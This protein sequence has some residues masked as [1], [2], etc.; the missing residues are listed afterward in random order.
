MEKK[1][2]AVA[3]A[4]MTMF[5]MDHDSEDTNDKSKAT[6]DLRNVYKDIAE[7]FPSIVPSALNDHENSSE[8]VQKKITLTE[9]CIQ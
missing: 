7:N 2:I 6:C 9:L 1:S 5:A 4:C 8:E 3:L